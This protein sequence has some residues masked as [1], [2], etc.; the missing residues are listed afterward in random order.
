MSALPQKA[1]MCGALA[2]VCF[3]PIADIEPSYSITS[4]A[5]RRR[6]RALIDGPSTISGDRHFS[7][8]VFGRSV[9]SRK[10]RVAGRLWLLALVFAPSW[11]VKTHDPAI[12]PKP[13]MPLH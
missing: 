12:V 9:C 1:D 3:G 8:A 7:D 2:H 11:V 5:A 4:S 13:P 10:A 6:V